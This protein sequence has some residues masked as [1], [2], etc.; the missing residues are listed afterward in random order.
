RGPLTTE[1]VITV[2]QDLERFSET[3]ERN[4]IDTIAAHGV[5]RGA[6]HKS[7][8]LVPVPSPEGCDPFVPEAPRGD[9]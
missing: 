1:L 7:G 2:R 5:F 6:A 3:L 4:R 9:R 8:N